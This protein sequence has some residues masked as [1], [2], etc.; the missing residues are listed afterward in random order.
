MDYQ[1]RWILHCDCDSFFASVEETFHPEYKKVPMAVAGSPENRHGIVVAKNHL[2][3]G[4]GIKTAETV[5]SA[6]KKCPGLLLVPPRSDTYSVF[7]DKVNAIFE[8]YTDQVERFS[9][10]E[11]WLD[12]TGSLRLF[13]EGPLEL[14]K[15]I[16]ARVASEIGITI[17]IGIS[18]NKMFAKLGSDM[19]KP[20][21][22][23]CITRENYRDIVWPLPV[24]DMFGVGRKTAALLDKHWMKTI[25]DLAA[26]DE[27]TLEH[28]FGKMGPELRRHANGEDDSPVGHITGEGE[29]KS[30]GNGM[31]F[32]RDLITEQD[33]RTGI[34]ALSDTVAS[35]L[36]RHRVK[37]STVQVTIKDT[38]LK[39]IQRQKA[40]RRPTNTAAE[41]THTAM[42]IINASWNI[43]Q[44]IRMLTITAQNL[45]K[46]REAVEQLSLFSE[47][48]NM[49]GDKVERVERAIDRIRWKHGTRSIQSGAILKNDL[50]ISNGDE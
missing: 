17:S 13:G 14:A 29:A 31:T 1:D 15:E 12:I 20:N 6:K 18:W 2:A 33:I 11:S 43:G 32:R 38:A 10:D 5:W 46:E 9:I 25:G 24:G 44:P 37:C 22:T 30:I 41:L 3:K 47:I 49:K 45:V 50:G 21:G 42:E 23:C 28:L 19:N 26:M 40:V 8:Q 7:S 35:R 36:R 34:I 48:K 16:Q 39:S 27:Q 4:Y